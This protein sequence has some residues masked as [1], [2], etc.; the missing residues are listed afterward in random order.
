[1][2]YI[3]IGGFLLYHTYIH[4]LTCHAYV[5]FSD[6]ALYLEGKLTA[7]PFDTVFSPPD[8][9]P[10]DTQGVFWR[11]LLSL[12]KIRAFTTPLIQEIFAKFGC[13]VLSCTININKNC[14]TVYFVNEQSWLN[15]MKKKI[16]PQTIGMFSLTML[17]TSLTHFLIG[18]SV[19]YHIINKLLL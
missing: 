9:V 13:I 15:A 2:L 4:E 19:I 11:F 3:G 7:N 5:G 12:V 14:A 18:S 8:Y 6:E 16:I 17:S 1:M 10:T